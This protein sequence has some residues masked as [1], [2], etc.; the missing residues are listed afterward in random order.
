VLDEPTSNLDLLGTRQI[1]SLVARVA[2]ERGKTLLLVEHKLDEAL[3]LADRVLVL[4]RGQVVRFGSPTEALQGGDLPGIFTRPSLVRLAERLGLPGLPLTAEAFHDLLIRSRPLRAIAPAAV[5]AQP[6]PRGEPIIR[7]DDVEFAYDGQVPA[8]RGVSLTIHRGEMVAIL[9]RNGSGKSTL[10]R[11]VNGLLRPARGRVC[12]LG[13]DI[14]PLT[15]AQL[16]R[17]VGFCFQNPNHQLITFR[18]REELGFGPRSLGLPEAEVERRARPLRSSAWVRP[19]RP[20]WPPSAA[21]RNSAWPW[22]A[23]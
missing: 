5:P 17:H 23:C 18:V 22:R 4:D 6:P 9:G 11:H 12:V 19:G 21:G 13:Q 3:P 7:F 10:V 2:R 14:A 1:L 8:L 20:M 16:A 15:T